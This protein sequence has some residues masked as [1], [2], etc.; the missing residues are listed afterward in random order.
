MSS[1]EFDKVELPALEG[2]RFS[3]LGSML[4]VSNCHLR[5]HLR[6]TPL[7]EV[8]FESRLSDSIKTT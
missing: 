3:E 2:L 4:Q 5:T 6:E 1:D 7:N 8:V